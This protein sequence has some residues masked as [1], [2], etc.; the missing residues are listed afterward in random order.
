MWNNCLEQ[1]EKLG[2]NPSL[3]A[4]R[5]NNLCQWFQN[6]LNFCYLRDLF[7]SCCSSHWDADYQ[8]PHQKPFIPHSQL[9]GNTLMDHLNP[10]VSCQK[11]EGGQ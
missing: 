9:Y 2:L 3:V 4:L 6:W 8:L 7:C 5:R 11:C 1:A 10:L